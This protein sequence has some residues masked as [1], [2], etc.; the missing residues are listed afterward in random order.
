MPFSCTLNN[1][2]LYLEHSFNFHLNEVKQSHPLLNSRNAFL[3]H[4]ERKV[5]V[6]VR[7]D[8][9]SGDSHLFYELQSTGGFALIT[10]MK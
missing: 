4:S 3:Q 1:F 9:K 6:P 7:N 5:P 8:I 2:T 10:L